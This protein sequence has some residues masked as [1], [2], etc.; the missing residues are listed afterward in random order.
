MTQSRAPKNF[1]VILFQ[2]L[3]GTT[4]FNGET[5]GLIF[6]ATF[7]LIPSGHLIPAA[8]WRTTFPVNSGCLLRNLVITLHPNECPIS[9][10]CFQ[11]S[12]VSNSSSHS[13]YWNVVHPVMGGRSDFP[14]PGR[15]TAT[16]V[17]SVFLANLGANSAQLSVLPPQPW[18][19]MILFFPVPCLTRWVRIPWIFLYSDFIEDSVV[20]KLESQKV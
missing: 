19:Q 4:F 6:L 18:R 14:N 8:P 3:V 11:R 12:L 10:G 15:S 17:A 9:V 13:E 16:T 5:S 1:P 7:C 2:I 20:Q